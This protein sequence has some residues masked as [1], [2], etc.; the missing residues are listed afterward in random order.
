MSEIDALKLVLRTLRAE[1]ERG[2]V[3]QNLVPCIHESEIREFEERHSIL[4]PPE[5]RY[6]LSIIGNGCEHLFKL[7]EM[8]QDFGFSRWSENDGFIGSLSKPFN[9]S[10]AWND[11]SGLPEYQAGGEEDP[12]W[13]EE[14]DRQ[15]DLFEEKYFFPID[16][17]IPISHLGCAIREW[18]V[19]TG[20]ERGSVWYDDRANFQGMRPLKGSDGKRLSFLEWCRGWPNG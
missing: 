15:R 18:L 2:D 14:Y 9:F 4:L 12:A 8:D 17:A 20:P 7:G 19:V 10:C 6:F 16:G 13:L 3:G 5:Y 11:L 1:F